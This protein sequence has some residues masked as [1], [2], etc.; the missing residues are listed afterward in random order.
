MEGQFE[1]DNQYLRRHA[2]AAIAKANLWDFLQRD[3]N[4]LG[5][6]IGHRTVGGESTDE[7]ALV[8]YVARKVPAMYLP[9]SRQIPRRV[10]VGPNP[11]EVD[12]LETGPAYFCAAPDRHIPSGVSCGPEADATDTGTLG[13]LVMDNADSAD[14]SLY[15]LSCCHVL[16]PAGAKI[17]DAIVQPGGGLAADIIA[18]LSDWVPLN[19]TGNTVDCAIA[20]VGNPN[21][22][23]N[24]MADP[25][26][27]VAGKGH[28]AVGLVV[29]SLPAVQG[30]GSLI[31]PISTVLEQLKVVFPAKDGS[32]TT[33]ADT[34]IEVSKDLLP[35]NVEMV[36]ASS[37]YMSS[38]AEAI[39]VDFSI[40]QM[41]FTGLIM[42]KLN[43]VWG[44]SGSLVCKGGSG[45]SRD[46]GG[47]GFGNFVGTDVSLDALLAK[48]FLDRRLRA[49]R[50]GKFAVDLYF[51]NESAF[52]ARARDV[53][54]KPQDQT[55]IRDLYYRYIDSIR[56]ALVA[57]GRSEFQITGEHLEMAQQLLRRAKKYLRA[58]EKQAAAELLELASAFDGR[59]VSEIL[60]LFDNE[61]VVVRVQEIVSHVPFLRRSDEK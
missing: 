10:Y 20:K 57:S 2:L 32:K 11:V 61:E 35:M 37:H 3:A 54:L 50:V 36:G 46:N 8:V 29:A 40:H 9:L 22:V 24:R 39:D 43:A 44:D 48:D 38:T 27:D 19:A 30:G 59:T 34:T 25:R 1:T 42:T 45:G 58:E 47:C 12:V 6:G 17:G 60:D 4:I 13:C 31:C 53:T 16:A 7:P 52:A 56:M 41:K 33:I 14:Q 21:D 15:I 28:P 18:T 23:D 55:Y 5:A 51:R 49:T 26:M